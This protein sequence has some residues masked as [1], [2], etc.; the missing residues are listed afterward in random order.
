MCKTYSLKVNDVVSSKMLQT[1][2]DDLVRYVNLVVNGNFLRTGREANLLDRIDS[3]ISVICALCKEFN[4]DWASEGVQSRS[5]EDQRD[6]MAA[7]GAYL[8]LPLRTL[9]SLM[10]RIRMLGRR[11]TVLNFQRQL[12]A[13]WHQHT[14]GGMAFSECATDPMVLILVYLTTALEC[15]KIWQRRQQVYHPIPW[16]IRV[17][18]NGKRVMLRYCYWHKNYAGRLVKSHADYIIPT[19][20]K[21]ITADGIRCLQNTYGN[22]QGKRV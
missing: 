20:L 22:E 7:F 19:E 5:M 21:F 18:R 10:T 12:D 16:T 2:K 8:E 15:H 9:S 17:S 4:L 13:Y 1:G 14:G 3:C 6:F 11:S